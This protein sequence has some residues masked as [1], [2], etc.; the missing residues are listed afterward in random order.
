MKLA[1][2]LAVL[3]AAA[4][5]AWAANKVVCYYD[6]RAY[7]REGAA[8]I[9]PVD[10]EPSLSLCTHLVYGYAVVDG[11]TNRLTP[12]D[13]YVD[14]DTNKG[15]YRLITSLK[16]RHPGLRVLLSV[17]G[18]ADSA[19]EKDK[20]L[21]LLETPEKRLEFVN[22][23]KQLLK[24]HNFDGLDLAWQF[25]VLKEKKD[26]G[27][28]G[29]VWHKIKKTFSGSSKDEKEEEHRDGFTSLVRELKAALR[30]DGLMLTAA[31]LPHVNSTVYYD[32][33]VL[34]PL[35]DHIHLMTYDFRTPERTPQEAD[36]PAPLYYVHD[37]KSYQNVDATV[38][39]WLEHGTDAVKII[40]GIPTFGR[41]WK[42]NAE[43]GISGVPPVVADGPGDA[44][45]VTKTPGIMAWQETCLLLHNSKV[46]DVP[47]DRLLRRVG[48]PSKRLGSYAYRL[49]KKSDETG[50]WV[51][52]EDTESAGYKAAWVK[53]RGLGGIAV[54]DLSMDDP[55]GV[56]DGNKF[57]ILRAAKNGL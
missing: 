42:L 28:L 56:C 41:S 35:L 10:L 55:R 29:S 5:P 15:Y 32:Y 33:R 22:S 14:L 49:P 39:R 47:N 48:D 45:T 21:T 54:F 4:A 9:E 51:G 26:R 57:P 3:C 12:M 16:A 17:G 37:R 34:A 18:G 44:G 11:N 24:H 46:A 1:V 30:G 7:W 19:G 52:Y 36:Y 6:S 13:D 40:V 2:V 20:Y 31:V 50:L 25:P 27:T 38:R 8:K 23:A 53:N 43:S